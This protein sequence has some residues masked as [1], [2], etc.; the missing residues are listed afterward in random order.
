MKPSN[1]QR[2]IIKKW[3]KKWR[4]RLFLGEWYI[5]LIYKKEPNENNHPGFTITA[6]CDADPVYMRAFVSIYPEFFRLSKKQM[7][8]TIVHELS[9]C[10]TQ[11]VWNC[12]KCLHQGELITPDQ[13]RSEIEQLTQRITNIAFQ[14]EW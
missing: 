12:M 13:M 5:D 8:E 1:A 14:D 4:L 6:T 3:I 7:E 9:H 11:S 10:H 2:A